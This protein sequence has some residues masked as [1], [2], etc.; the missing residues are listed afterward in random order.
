MSSDGFKFKKEDEKFFNSNWLTRYEVLRVITKIDFLDYNLLDV[1]QS[2]HIQDNYKSISKINGEENIIDTS[3]FALPET[4]NTKEILMHNTSAYINNKEV[5]ITVSSKPNLVKLNNLN[6]V[7]SSMR[8]IN[9]V[10]QTIE[11]ELKNFSKKLSTEDLVNDLDMYRN[12]LI[13]FFH[14]DS[15]FSQYLVDIDTASKKFEVKFSSLEEADEKLIWNI[16]RLIKLIKKVEY[17]QAE[18]LSTIIYRLELLIEKRFNQLIAIDLPKKLYKNNNILDSDNH[19]TIKLYSEELYKQFLRERKLKKLSFLIGQ[20]VD[21]FMVL[22]T[23]DW[24]SGYYEIKPPQNTRITKVE[25][26]QHSRFERVKYLMETRESRENCNKSIEFE[27]KF[28]ERL[29]THIARISEQLKEKIKTPWN[30]P[31]LTISFRISPQLALQ[32]WICFT[33]CLGI[34][35]S[36]FLGVILNLS[37]VTDSTSDLFSILEKIISFSTYQAFW[38]F[39]LI[40]GNQLWLKEPKFLWK[41]STWVSL[42]IVLI[43]FVFL[44]LNILIISI[45]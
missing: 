24:G 21:F 13:V 10:K 29:V 40:I 17:N 34:F 5:A 31:A 2:F 33:I 43:G 41:N 39:G 37:C 20:R 19:F 30:R 35:Y 18:I 23:Y 8:I 7:Y 14:S 38:I 27:D 9:R 16:K 15:K 1:F 6:I 3:F 32:A 42:F 11:S 22:Y 26:F 28:N 12:T 4:Y 45:K 36:S 25:R 44:L